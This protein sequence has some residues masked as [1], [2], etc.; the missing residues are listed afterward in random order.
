MMK[1][2]IPT[3]VLD[4]ATGTGDLAV[5]VAK[6]F[7]NAKVIGADISENMLEIGK[8][9]MIRKK[10]NDRVLMEMGDSENLKYEDGYFDAV[11]VAFGVRNYE[12][13]PKGLNEM[14]RVTK[15][16][17]RV[18][19]LEFS[20]P[21]AFPFKQIYNFYFLRVLPLFGKTVSKDHHAYTYLPESVQQFPD[22]HDFLNYLEDS[23]YQDVSQKRLT[24][25][26]ASI[27]SGKKAE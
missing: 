6:A 10:L 11:T 26:I 8:Q 19:I 25:G 16:G 1:K 4:I 20:K 24:F 7:P 23:G 3:Q 18:Y 9:K 13:L 27:Y 5:A 21:S 14:F 2:Q 15:K 17:G 12:D 22:G